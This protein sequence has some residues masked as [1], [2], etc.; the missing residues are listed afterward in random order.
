MK[1]SRRKFRPIY[2]PFLIAYGTALLCVAFVHSVR[3]MI[4]APILN[5]TSGTKN[6]EV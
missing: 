4:R 5:F 3:R 6:A 2:L 1:N